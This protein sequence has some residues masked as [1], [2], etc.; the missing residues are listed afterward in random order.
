MTI[1]VDKIGVSY[2][3]VPKCACTSIK[4]LFFDIENGE[5]YRGHIVSGVRQHIHKVYPASAFKPAHARDNLCVAAI[6][7]PVERLISC[8]TNR[9]LYHGELERIGP[10]FIKRGAQKRPTLGHFVNHLS[11]YREASGSVRH[12][13]EP[14]VHFLGHDASFYDHIFRIDQLEGLVAL[15]EERTGRTLSL[16]HRQSGGPKMS[17][18]DLNERQ[19]ERARAFYADDYAAFGHLL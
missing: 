1:I 15:L 11:L 14:M 2:F 13:S 16:Q 17:R 4:H 7:D 5:P 19:I 10:Q 12:H 6:R 3:P 18:A 8:Y 9:V